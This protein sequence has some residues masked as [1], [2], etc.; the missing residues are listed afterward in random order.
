MCEP[1]NLVFI[2]HVHIYAVCV[3]RMLGLYQPVLLQ[4]LFILFI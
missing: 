1:Q 4:L 3:I 2:V